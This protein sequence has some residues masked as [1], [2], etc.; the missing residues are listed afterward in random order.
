[1]GLYCVILLSI[2]CSQVGGSEAEPDQRAGS[3]ELLGDGTARVTGVVSSNERYCERDLACWLVLEIEGR[4][5]EVYYSGVGD[6][7]PCLNSKAYAGG[8]V[9]D[10]DHRVEVFAAVVSEG[11]PVRLSLCPE[12]RFYVRVLED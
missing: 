12:E 9:V 3:L 6:G 2:A 7:D 1:M 10:A 5:V 11:D 4:T 8:T